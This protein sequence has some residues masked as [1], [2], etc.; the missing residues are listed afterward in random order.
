MLQVLECDEAGAVTA[1]YTQTPVSP[2]DGRETTRIDTI[3]PTNPK[4]PWQRGLDV[5]LP[6]G[7][8]HSVTDD[9]TS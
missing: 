3:H 4:R 1:T 7:Y 9:Y 8:P 6:A 2:S 5:F